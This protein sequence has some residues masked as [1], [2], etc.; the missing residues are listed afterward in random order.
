MNS[1]G[2]RR[3]LVLSARCRVAAGWLPA[4]GLVEAEGIPGDAVVPP[5]IGTGGDLGDLAESGGEPCFVALRSLFREP[6]V[7]LAAVN[8]VLPVIAELPHR[9]G[10]PDDDEGVVAVE[11]DPAVG[12]GG[13]GIAICHC[14][15]GSFLS[16]GLEARGD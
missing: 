14:H 11:Q 10:E 12:T 3:G 7:G 13:S 5:R 8:D 4:R 15:D 6:G 16:D 2:G 9:E 1:A